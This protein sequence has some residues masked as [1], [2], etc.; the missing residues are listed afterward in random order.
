[1]GFA[2]SLGAVLAAVVPTTEEYAKLADDRPPDATSLAYLQVLT[3]A[4]PGDENLRLLYVKHLKTLGRYDEAV[5][6]LAPA[7]ASHPDSLEIASLQLD[8][9]LAR[10]RAIPEEDPRRAQ[11]FVAV[12]AHLRGLLGFRQ[13]EKLE[14]WMMLAVALDRPRL[15]A[16]F[17][18]AAA[19]APGPRGA[20]I[21]AEAARWMRASGD[22]ERAARD[23]RAAADREEDP[24]RAR[25]DAL[26]ALATLESDDRVGDAA[27]LAGSY[28]H[29]W[30]G[31][32]ELLR[33][34][35][36]LATGC[37]RPGLAR[38]YGRRLLA[39]E[40]S[41]DAV[42]ERQVELE[43]A[44]GDARA[45]LPLIQRL[46]ALRPDDVGLHRQEARVAEEIGE[47][48]VALN[49]WVWL[50]GRGRHHQ[51]ARGALLAQEPVRR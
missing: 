48:Q 18:H 47:P 26:L 38:D 13:Q 30:P 49:E 46:I 41:S 5:D 33:R 15:A 28:L 27:D 9:L 32:A 10:A 34:A 20:S 31:D 50:L 12:E 25:Q 40:P 39:L 1:V 42:L 44:S 7:L 23:Y 11:A 2:F 35:A 29:R 51:A 45:A 17:G 36:D 21:L 4:S 16:E 24:E 8:L 43:L 22:A 19:Q 3:R 14:S 6:V 37:G